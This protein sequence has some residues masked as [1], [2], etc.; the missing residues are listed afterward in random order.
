MNTRPNPPSEPRADSGHGQEAAVQERVNQLFKK[1]A[2]LDTLHALE[3]LGTVEE[4]PEVMQRVLKLIGAEEPK[5]WLGSQADHASLFSD[6]SQQPDLSGTE[7][8]NFRL[9]RKL[10][11]GG[12]GEVYLAE[13]TRLQRQVAV[14]C[15]QGAHRLDARAK[16]RLRREAVI[17]SSLDHPA[18]CRIYNLIETDSADYLILELVNGRTLG[19]WLADHNISLRRK[20]VVAQ[21]LLD[22]VKTAHAAEIIHRDLKPDNIMVLP[23]DQVKVLD[24]GIS[25]VL[26]D[27]VNESPKANVPLSMQTLPGAMLGTLDF[28]SPEQA[29]GKAVGPPADVYSL[30]V[31]LQQI[32]STQTAHPS[33]L[34]PDAFLQR[35]RS[36]ETNPVQGATADLTRLIE[37]M[38]L[39]VATARPT[40]AE[41]LTLLEKIRQKPARRLRWALLAAVLLVAALGIF[42]YTQD[43]R[44]E[45]AQAEAARTEAEQVADFLASLFEVSNPNQSKG[46]DIT[47]RQILAD[48]VARID[49]ELEQQPR[50][51]AKLKTTIAAVYANLGLYQEASE[52]FKQALNLIEALQPVDTAL[53]V[54]ILVTY[55]GMDVDRAEYG[56]A[57]PLLDQALS[58]VQEQPAALQHLQPKVWSNLAVLYSRTDRRKESLDLYQNALAAYLAEP[59]RNTFDIVNEYN[60]IGMLHWREERLEEAQTNLQTALN[61]YDQE[62][63]DDL[64]F[65][66]TAMNNL[67]LVVGQG[68]N[69][70]EAAD[71]AESSV[72]IWQKILDP[73]HPDLATAYDNLA[74]AMYRAGRLEDAALWN[75]R[76]LE[77]YEAQF[78]RQ[79][80][81]F[82]YALSNRGVVLREQ[83]D[84]DGAEKA[85]VEIVETA[86]QLIGEPASDTIFYRLRLGDLYLRQNRLSEAL[87]V[88]RQAQ[89]SHIEAASTMQSAAANAW[90]QLATI[91]QRMGDEQGA[92]QTLL[93]LITRLE[94][95]LA[96][97]PDLVDKANAALLDLDNPVA[98][99]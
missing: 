97:N 62:G 14:K 36:G 60:N 28:M 63:M 67:A 58:L 78:G 38:K 4:S 64:A 2:E 24:F 91:Q 75:L 70:E 59:H 74:V 33:G 37:R 80:M 47:A 9:V 22:A 43:L 52:Q 86:T 16:E 5:G 29:N 76:A 15:I 79:H 65:K 56:T 46:E 48:G 82:A 8:D 6:D 92:R 85:F 96:H 49:R 25:R 23:N 31:I 20:L 87:E 71:L 19:E 13:D 50:T 89:G 99:E 55:G 77:I 90:F 7:V 68:G 32:F 57:E 3:Y 26:G 40:A 45:R 11:A 83:G 69:S 95:D 10:G 93:D 41:A 44:F 30:G 34:D 61:I 35:A 98:D 72:Q 54:E 94:A 88:T 42:K 1:V 17:L 51:L 39:K 12:M 53:Q 27:A 21:S 66:A 84:M 81:H 18:I 73:G